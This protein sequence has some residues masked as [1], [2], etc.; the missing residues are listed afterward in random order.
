MILTA[1]TTPEDLR[2]SGRS[3]RRLS[4]PAPW[5]WAAAAVLTAGAL[6]LTLTVGYWAH[7]ARWSGPLTALL[8]GTWLMSGLLVWAALMLQRQRSPMR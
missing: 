7:E 4:A 3:W 1:R 6:G 2:R 5:L 8:V